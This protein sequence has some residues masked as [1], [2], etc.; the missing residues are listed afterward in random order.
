MGERS[1][2]ECSRRFGSARPH[3]RAS[4]CSNCRPRSSRWSKS[5]PAR[6]VTFSE[7]ID[8]H[9]DVT[10]LINGEQHYRADPVT[11]GEL[12]VWDIV[13]ASSI[14]H[15]FHLHGF[16][17]QVLERNGTPPA[18]RSWGRHR[19]CSGWRACSHCVDAG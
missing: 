2:G 4:A 17:F 11:V 1:A 19:E 10:F 15:P 3:P 9:G 6:E 7:R 18:Y 16:F 5:A 13:N 8:A 14:D 12:Q